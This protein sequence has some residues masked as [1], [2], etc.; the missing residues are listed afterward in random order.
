MAQAIINAS[1]KPA[2]EPPQILIWG[3]ADYEDIFGQKHFVE[4]CHE[5]RF[6]RTG[7]E[8]MRPSTIQFG[9]YNRT[10]DEPT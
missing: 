4:W 1:W 7:G 10:D 2:E 8:R 3:R 6:S 9:K 5:L